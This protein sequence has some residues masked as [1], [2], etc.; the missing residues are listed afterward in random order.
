VQPAWEPWEQDEQRPLQGGR[1][2]RFTLEPGAEIQ[3]KAEYTI[4]VYIKNDLVG[5]NRREA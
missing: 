3:L 1:R 2:W 4:K 5:G